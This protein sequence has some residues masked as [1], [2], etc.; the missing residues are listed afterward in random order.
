MGRIRTTTFTASGDSS[1]F[2]VPLIF[3]IGEYDL[4]GGR[5]GN[6][7][8]DMGGELSPTNSQQ[9]VQINCEK[10]GQTLA[11][12]AFWLAYSQFTYVK[13]RN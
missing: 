12:T 2:P 1:D 13:P 6:A 7:A 11:A 9:P 5:G 10:P 3:R 8:P 4:E